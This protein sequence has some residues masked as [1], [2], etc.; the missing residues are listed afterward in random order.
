MLVGRHL[1]RVAA[2]L[3]RPLSSRA[4]L[5]APPMVFIKGE[6]MTSYCMDLVME[7]WVHPHVDTSA[8]EFFDL[9][10]RS[11]DDTED[12]VLHDAVAAGARI[13]AIFK[14]PTVTPTAEQQ[15]KLG[16]KKAWGSPNGAMRRG[17]NG[18]TISRDTIHIEG[19]ELGYKRPVLFERHAVGGEYGAGFK[20]VGAG[21]V[22]TTF[23]PSDGAQPLLVDSRDLPDASNAVVTYHNPLDNVPDLAHHFFT[24]CLAAEVTPYVVTKKTVFKWQE[25]FWKAMKTTFDAHYKER[26][27][28][29]GLL[30][31]CGGELAHLIS[32]AATMQ[33]IRWTDGGF[34]MAAH[35]YDGDMLTDEVSQVRRTPEP[36]PWP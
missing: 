35:N 1:G 8:W 12:Q 23:H 5:V 33:I 34:G 17:W 14:E 15:A 24:R 7:K 20:E 11:R 36:W 28:A 2:Q 10:C 27:L 16:L 32:D 31:K 25:G 3:R 26:Y 4:K 22:I 21:K 6:E 29:A 18:I 13:G 19:M 9:S 30:D